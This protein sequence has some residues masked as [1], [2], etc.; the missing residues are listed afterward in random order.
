MEIRNSFLYVLWSESSQWQFPPAP[1]FFLYPPGHSYHTFSGLYGNFHFQSSDHQPFGA[2]PMNSEV[3]VSLT[4][5]L[6]LPS[7]EAV[8]SLNTVSEIVSC[9]LLSLLKVS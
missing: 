8:T 7:L 2:H 5:L 1:S 9:S 6:W 4:S 3:V